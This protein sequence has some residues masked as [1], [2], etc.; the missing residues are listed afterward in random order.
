[1]SSRADRLFDAV[2]GRVELPDFLAT[3]GE[4]GE[5]F[6]AQVAA[7]LA[8]ITAGLVSP[9]WAERC[10]ARQLVDQM[11]TEGGK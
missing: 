1:M 3:R 10:A 6:F 8:A 9:K 4:A 11:I 2:A 7:D 5:L